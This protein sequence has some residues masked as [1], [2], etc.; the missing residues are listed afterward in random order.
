MDLIEE[1]KKR[2]HKSGAI[3]QRYVLDCSAVKN[4]EIEEQAN[5]DVRVYEFSKLERTRIEKQG[6]YT[7]YNAETNEWVDL[8]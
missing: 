5:G 8:L 3:S 6:Y 7:V 2:E 1:I 4:G